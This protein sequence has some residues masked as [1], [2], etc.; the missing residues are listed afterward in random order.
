MPARCCAANATNALRISLRQDEASL[1]AEWLAAAPFPHL[2]LD[3]F[4]PEDSFGELFE[5]L[6]EEPVE[7]YRAEIYTF[8]ASKPQPET[9]ALAALR[10]AF[11]ESLAPALARITKKPALTRTEMRAYA[12]R[13]GHYLLPHSDQGQDR[14]IAYAYYAPS[15]EPVTGGEL[16]LFDVVLEDREIIATTSAKL[17]EPRANR[18][19]LF[20]VSDVSLHQVREVLSGLRISL[21]GWFYP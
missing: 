4:L 12:Y 9:V 1:A 13:P 20:D 7:T 11:T 10:D 14:A 16:E 2:I 19:V 8:D 3:D 15:P 6:E 5:I 21:S 18:I 17:I